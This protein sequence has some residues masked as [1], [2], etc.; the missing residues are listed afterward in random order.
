VDGST[1]PTIAPH[2][3]QLLDLPI[4]IDSWELFDRLFEWEKRPLNSSLTGSTYL[5]AAVRSFFAQGGRRCYVIRVG[6]PWR[7]DSLR[8]QKIE[9][10][11]QLIPGYPLVVSSVPTDQTSWQGVGHLL[12]LP[13][14]S[15]VCLPDLTDAI[16]ADPNHCPIRSRSPTSRT[17]C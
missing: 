12:G 2:P 8:S 9:F 11:K 4:P 10:L 16:A 7:F 1:R 3:E 5:G 13:D 6:D 15:F 17:V 14:V